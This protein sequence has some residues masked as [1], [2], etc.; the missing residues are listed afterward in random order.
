MP[1]NLSLFRT[2]LL[3]LLLTFMAIGAQGVVAQTQVIDFEQYE[4]GEILT[5]VAGSEGYSGIAVSATHPACPTRNAAIIFDSSCPGGCSGD[6]DDLGTP[7][8]SFGGPGTGTGGAAGSG[9]END[10]ALGNLLVVHQFCSDLNSSPVANPQDFGGNATVHLTFPTDVTI[11]ELTTLDV[12]GSETLQIDF[13]DEAGNAVGFANPIVTGDN[14]KAILAAMPLGGNATVSAVRTM[15]ITRQGSGALDNIVFTPDAVADLEITKLVDNPAPDSGAT[16]VFTLD[17]VNQ[18]PDTAANVTVDDRV[19]VGLNYVSHTCDTGITNLDVS[20]FVNDA[21]ETQQLIRATLDNIAAGAS[22]SCTV[23]TTV[24]TGVAVENVVEIMTS[25]AYDPDSTPGNNVPDEDDQDSAA[26]TPGESSGGGDGGIESE[27]TMAI[28]LAQRLFNRRVDTQHKAALL[29]APAPQVFLPTS[30]N[31]IRL[32]KAGSGLDDLRNAIPSEGPHTSLAYEVTPRDL[33][34][35]TNATG[36]LAVD[37]LQVNGRRLGAIFS[38]SSPTGELYDHT[39]VSCDRLGGGKLEDV[40]LVQINGQ[41]FVLSKLRHATGDIDY[42]ISFVAYRS[43]SAYTIDSRFSPAEYTVPAGSEVINVQVWG[44]TPEFSAG[45]IADLL[46]TLSE[47][48]A[49]T[50][51]N[52]AT[53]APQIFVADGEYTQGK[54]NLRLVNRAGAAQV[55]IRGTLAATEADAARGIRIP[56]AQT[57]DLNK[58]TA[59]FPY[60]EITLDV[61][62]IFDAILTVEHKA[63]NSLDQLYHADGTWSYASGDESEVNNF[64]TASNKQ[65][66][67]V[68]RYIVERSG[69]IEGHVKNWVSL[70]RY[71]QPNGKAVDLSAYNYVSFTASGTGQVRLIAEKASIETWDQYGF[72]FELTE[73]PKRH[74][75]SFSEMRKEGRFDGRFEANDITLLAFYALGDGQ[76]LQPFSMDINN[77]TFGGAAQVAGEALPTLYTL[78]QNFPNPFN[79][80]TQINFSLLESMRVRLAVYDVLGREVAVLVDGLQAAGTHQVPFEAGDLPSGLYMY[81]IETPQGSTSKMMSLLK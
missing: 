32:A 13:F 11:T 33:L 44:V 21:G 27:G 70:F 1:L 4:T 47:R 42:A 63:S 52:N 81:R 77:I 48:N 60:A 10:T 74:S 31:A 51:Q 43:G 46:N 80:V 36:V 41:D 73:E 35:I 72:T 14:G 69:S 8:A 9:Y 3:A 37:Y 18:G 34:G 53:R 29:A 64:F 56:F 58:P 50:Y 62:S 54:I 67:T 2:C 59:D 22:A 6:D 16:V 28:Q 78:E 76:Q 45:V 61:G 65:L 17:L 57:V 24:D 55:I 25:D 75:I 39:K 49:L 19:P 7:N 5:Y 26:I 66:Y 79:P 38:T 40:R 12:E 20:S 30:E 15:S 68:D 71:L 23:S